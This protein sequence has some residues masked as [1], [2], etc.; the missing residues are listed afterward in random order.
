MTVVGHYDAVVVHADNS[1][2]EF[3]ERFGFTDDM[4]LN[5]RFRW[6]IINWICQ[7]VKHMTNRV[8]TILTCKCTKFEIWAIGLAEI[9]ITNL[10]NMIGW[11]FWLKSK[12]GLYYFWELQPWGIIK[13]C[14]W[15]FLAIDFFL[16]IIWSVLIWK[17]ILK[18]DGTHLSEIR[19]LVE[20]IHVAR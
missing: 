14:L 7:N 17:V 2:T 13:T 15:F 19:V 9:I 11:E 6:S 5:S 3:F 20:Y 10:S 4:V 1:A 8:L 12:L 18:T 16:L